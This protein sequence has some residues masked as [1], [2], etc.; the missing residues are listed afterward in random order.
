MNDFS[1]FNT[2]SYL[3]VILSIFMFAYPYTNKVLA[4]TPP[5]LSTRWHL[6]TKL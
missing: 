3:I 1:S 4:E 5:H 2:C 6:L